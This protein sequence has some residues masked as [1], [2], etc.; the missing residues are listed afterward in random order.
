MIPE[1]KQIFESNNNPTIVIVGGGFAGLR[2]VKILKDKA[3]RVILIDRNNYHT[4]QP[5]LYQVATGS[6]TP[7]SIAYPFRKTIAPIN[8][9]AF[10]K[11]EVLSVDTANNMVVTDKGNIDYDYLVI[12]TGSKTRFFGNKSIE[13]WAMQLKSIPQALDIRSDFLQEFEE[14]IYLNDEKAQ[15][16]VL[17]FVVVGGGPTGVEVSG[18]LAEIKRNILKNEYREVNSNLMQIW[19]IEANERLLKT[20]SEKSSLKALRFLRKMGVNVRLNTRVVSYDGS[21]IELNNGVKLPTETVI[22]SAGVQGS[23][24]KGLESALDENSGRYHVDERSALKGYDNIFAVGDI[25]QMK[26][27]DFPYGHPMVAPTAI[28]QAEHLCRN[29]LAR[30]KGKPSKPFVYKDKGSMATIGRHKAVVDMGKIHLSGFFAWWVWM[31]VHLFSIV[32]FKNRVLILFIWILKYFSFKNT[33]RLIIHPYM[34]KNSQ[35]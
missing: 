23:A 14:A 4:F 18:A 24:I 32:G 16:R 2:M 22:W 19:L 29:F 25:A 3:Y 28:Q 10:R 30:A 7:D 26:T 20:F 12:A 1:G 8:N 15:S 33:I 21:I 11:A 13:S 31:F 5:L 17:N 34:R 35:A 9:T 27:K 6:L